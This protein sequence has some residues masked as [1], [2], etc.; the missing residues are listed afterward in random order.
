MK[1]KRYPVYWS[2]S[3]QFDLE[4]IIDYIAAE[5]IANARRVFAQIK[6]GCIKLERF[7]EIGK[8]PM[9]LRDVNIDSYREIIVSVWKIIYRVNP[10]SVSILAVIDSRRNRDDIL[11]TRLLN[12]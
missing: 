3:A 8:I 5:S 11:L 7:P 6:E 12:R 2:E 4:S 1:L 10:E 9:E